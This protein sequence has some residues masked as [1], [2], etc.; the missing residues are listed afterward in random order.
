MLVVRVS[1]GLGNEAEAVLE[2]DSHSLATVEPYQ[3]WDC[4]RDPPINTSVSFARL[5]TFQATKLIKPI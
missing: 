3:I 1:R 5:Q 4:M 2:A